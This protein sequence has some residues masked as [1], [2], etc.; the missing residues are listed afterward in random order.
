MVE[1]LDDDEKAAALRGLPDLP[2]F[3]REIAERDPSDDA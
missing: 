2:P 1:S 3:W